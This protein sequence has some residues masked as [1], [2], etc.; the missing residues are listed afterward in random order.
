MKSPERINTISLRSISSYSAHQEVICAVFKGDKEANE[1]S[2]PRIRGC[3]KRAC[4]KEER[5]DAGG[6]YLQELGSWKFV[7]RKADIP[8]E[9]MLRETAQDNQKGLCSNV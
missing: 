3:C 9:F 7:A 8:N 4:T 2:V 6:C 5:G 1:Q